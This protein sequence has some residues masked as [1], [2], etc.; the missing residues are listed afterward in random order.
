MRRIAGVTVAGLMLSGLVIPAMHHAAAR[1]PVKPSVVRIPLVAGIA[2]AVADSPAHQKAAAS[3]SSGVGLQRDRS[4]ASVGLVAH[5]AAATHASAHLVREN[6]AKFGLVALTWRGDGDGLSARIRV[7]ERGTW[8]PWHTVSASQDGPDAHSDDAR[9]A[10]NRAGTDPLLTSGSSDAVEAVVTTT[11]SQLPE[12]LELVLIDGRRNAADNLTSTVQSGA[13]HADPTA[14]DIISR[15]GWGADETLRSGDVKYSATIKVGFVHHTVTASNYPRSQ[16]AAQVRAVYAYDT[17][18]LGISDMGYNFLVDRFGTIYEGRAGG[19]DKAVIGAHTAGFNENSF[20]VAVLGDFQHDRPSSTTLSAVVNAVGSVAGWKLGLFHRDP[21]APV[22]LV[23]TGKYGTSKYNAGEVARMPYTLIGHGDIGATAC[24]GK[25]LRTQLGLIRQVA[26]KVQSPAIWSPTVTPDATSWATSASV[27]ISATTS[28]RMDVTLSIFSACAADAVRVINRAQSVAG[29]ESF[30]WDLRDDS[31]KAVAPGRYRLVLS[32]KTDSG[33]VPWSTS[34]VVDIDPTADSPPGPCAAVSRVAAVGT[35]ADALS[36]IASTSTTLVVASSAATENTNAVIAAALARRLKA[37]LLLSA[38]AGLDT[39]TLQA[40]GDDGIRRAVVV[41]TTGKLTQV[42]SGLRGIGIASVD[43]VEAATPAQV[44]LSAVRQGWPKA[45]NITAVVLPAGSAAGV[46][47]AAGAFAVSRSYPL[48][49]VP[50]AA[51][52]ASPSNS[53]SVWSSATGSGGTASTSASGAAGNAPTPPAVS[54]SAATSVQNS[55]APTSLPPTA[56]TAVPGSAVAINA[57]IAAVGVTKTIVVGLSS[58]LQSAGYSQIPTTVQISGGSSASVALAMARK[59]RT[60]TEVSVTTDASAARGYA[61]LAAVR[62]MPVLVLSGGTLSAATTTWIASTGIDRAALLGSRA[63][64]SPDIVG[65]LVIAFATQMSPT[66]SPTS[67][68]STSTSATPS[69]SSSPSGSGTSP[70]GTQS[71]ASASPTSGIPLAFAVNGAGFGHGIGMPQYGAQ[72]QAVA[73][74]TAREI[75]EYYY[76]GAKVRAVSDDADIRVNLIHQ[77]SSVTFR[78]RAVDSTPGVPSNDPGARADLT[79]QGTSVVTAIGDT[80]TAA[81]VLTKAGPRLTLQR[82][83]ASGRTTTLGS[84]PSVTVRWGGTRDSG[85]AGSTPAYI[86]IA[87]PSESLGDGYGRYRYGTVSISAVSFAQAGVNKAGLEVVNAL[88]I[89][90]EYLRGIGEVPASWKPAALQAQVI[91]SRGYAL[92]AL[93]GAVKPGCD[94]HVYDSDQ[95]QVFAGWTREVGFS[96]SAGLVRS[97]VS[98]SNSPTPTVKSPTPSTSTPG[99]K[100]AGAVT[101]TP[102]TSSPSPSTSN[103][104]PTGSPS[105]SASTTTSATPTPRP[106]ATAELPLPDYSLGRAWVKAVQATCPAPNTGLAA[107]VSGKVIASYFFSASAGKTENSEDI[108]TARLSWARSVPDP[109]STDASVVP[110]RLRAWQVVLSQ[111]DVADFFGLRDVVRI[112]ISGRTTGGAVRT[113]RATSFNGA[114]ATA[115]AVT[116]RKQFDLKSRWFSSIVPFGGWRAP[117]G[118]SSASTAPTSSVTPS[119]SVTP[120]MTTSPTATRP[121]STSPSPSTPASPATL[122]VQDMQKSSDV[123]RVTVRGRVSRA[124][125]GAYVIA[126]QKWRGSW[127]ELSRMNVVGSAPWSTQIVLPAGQSELRVQL[128]SGRRV[129]ATSKSWRISIRVLPVITVTAPTKVARHTTFTLSGR[130]AHVPQA[131]MVQRQIR[132]EGGWQPRGTPVAITR[133]VWTMKVTAPRNR[134]V[135]TYQ[136][137]LMQGSK[138]LARSSVVTV[139]VK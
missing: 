131:A 40:L 138:V 57:A 56:N 76:S 25:Y 1:S 21:M 139:N 93:R 33:A 108:W 136:L 84:F 95:S 74:R 89:H 13:V 9:H 85:G 7:R 109:W 73:G 125:R 134:G 106:S 32:G 51:S 69:T 47:A 91:A 92:S 112:D 98:V 135:L 28:D 75:V 67:S 87:G 23:S 117:T 59:F 48:L 14:P 137:L 22:N 88:R 37:R 42:V 81:A 79:T 19:I 101:A 82:T 10:G 94:C 50:P 24:P 110:Q 39:S 46:V 80:F 62:A 118:S 18:G 27:A 127:R 123:S 38:D 129:L 124:P 6:T 35:V 72:A 96:R 111:A 126:A 12:Q 114:T 36:T 44:S 132:T 105:G 121:P 70:G 64:V 133:G 43:V 66:P 71:S 8:Q 77:S 31:G 55:I 120:T 99:S 34:E 100:S 122:T 54:T 60:A 20:A 116:L 4:G 30:T 103:T 61:V 107:T 26:R 29:D 5:R 119:A 90:D 97:A 83:D 86:D 63:S 2:H 78:T 49:V 15:A 115:N 3:Q 65:P 45:Q 113:L 41:S 68:G 16:A 102:S 104:S 11:A 128:R 53:A 17:L 52:A 58:V 130:A